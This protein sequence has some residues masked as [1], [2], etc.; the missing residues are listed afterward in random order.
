MFPHVKLVRRGLGDAFER[1]GFW[2][3]R[4]QKAQEV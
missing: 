4:L 1:E 3:E 2:D